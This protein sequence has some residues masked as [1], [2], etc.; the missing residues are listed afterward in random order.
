MLSSYIDKKYLKYIFDSYPGKS[1]L[2]IVHYMMYMLE[3]FK[4]YK[5]VFIAQGQKMDIGANGDE[6]GDSSIKFY[7]EMKS[8]EETRFLEYFPIVE[9]IDTLETMHIKDDGTWLTEDFKITKK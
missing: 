5:I 8:L 7:D 6:N 4:S 3:F 9:E 1:G 2:S